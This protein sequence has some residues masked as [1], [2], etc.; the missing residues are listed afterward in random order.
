MK[1][2]VV[3]FC[4]CA[5]A[6]CATGWSYAKCVYIYEH[7]CVCCI[8]WKTWNSFASTA[9]SLLL[10]CLIAYN[11]FYYW[12]S[13]VRRL[14]NGSA[15]GNWQ[16]A[17]GKWHPF[18]CCCRPFYYTSWQSELAGSNRVRL[19][20]PLRLRLWVTLATFMVA[21]CNQIVASWPVSVSASM[22]VSIYDW[23]FKLIET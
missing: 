15:I 1:P 3:S 11:N 18:V 19:P 12:T 7:G 22:C 6:A 23:R 20:L 14:S 4:D 13:Q 5:Y 2:A 17:T 21:E 16:R 10:F 8:N 9:H